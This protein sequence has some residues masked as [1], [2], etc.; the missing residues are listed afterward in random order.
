MLNDVKEF[1]DKI[2]VLVGKF[3]LDEQEEA[4]DI[5]L[6]R[7]LQNEDREMATELVKRGYRLIKDYKLLN[8]DIM[9]F[10]KRCVKIQQY[11]NKHE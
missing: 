3:P 10:Y 11:K 1:A 6:Y 9:T 8:D 5:Q 4:K 2:D 7:I